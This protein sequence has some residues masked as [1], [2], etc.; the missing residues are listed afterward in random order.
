MFPPRTTLSEFSSRI[1]V[2]I[3]HGIAYTAPNNRLTRTWRYTS[4]SKIGSASSS[5][6]IVN[7]TTAT[8]K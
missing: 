8:S 5:S 7:A 3:P 2:R 1:C 6:Q 4:V